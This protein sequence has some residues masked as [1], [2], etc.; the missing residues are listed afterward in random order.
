MLHKLVSRVLHATLATNI[1]K[2]TVSVV[3]AKQVARGQGVVGSEGR[4]YCTFYGHQSYAMCFQHNDS[5]GKSKPP[6]S[7]PQLQI[8]SFGSWTI[9]L[10]VQDLSSE[11]ISVWS[12]FSEVS[13][14]H[15]YD[16]LCRNL[17]TGLSAAQTMYEGMDR[18]VLICMMIYRCMHA[19]SILF[20]LQARS[21]FF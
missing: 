21:T 1:A 5:H 9:S 12:N 15:N 7:A 3:I 10:N 20:Y 14:R 6:F 19:S 8:Q 2:N 13:I 4:G 11:C 18:T 16:T 17:P